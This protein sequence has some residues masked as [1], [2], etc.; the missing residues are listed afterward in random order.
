M[1]TYEA[2]GGVSESLKT[3]LENTIELPGSIPPAPSP[4]PVWIGIPPKDDELDGNPLLNLFLY[5]ITESPF[6]K[7]Q[8]IPRQT[9]QTSYG[10]PPLSLV[11]HY[12]VTP[13]GRLAGNGGAGASPDEVPAHYVLGSAM[14]VL[15]DNPVLTSGSTAAGNI[16]L[17]PSLD[18]AYEKVKLR[19]EPI[20]L[21]DVSKVWTALGRPYRLS[22]AYELSVI[23]IESRKPRRYPQLVGKPPPEGPRVRSVA[24]RNP[25]I[26][27]VQGRRLPGPYAAVDDELVVRGEDLAGDSPRVFFGDVEAPVT[28]ARNDRLTVLVPDDPRLALGPQRV[29]VVRQ[30]EFGSPPVL[31]VGARSNTGVWMFVPRVDTVDYFAGGGAPPWVRV[32]GKRLYDKNLRCIA[33][34]DDALIESAD[35]TKKDL[36][37]TEIG[38]AFPSPPAA[39]S[40]HRVRVL[41]NEVEALAVPLVEVP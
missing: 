11:L 9:P 41:V 33:F 38:V 23:Q 27:E 25:L 37:G 35:W 5:R 31:R 6:L 19:L 14:R 30:V 40:T 12:L 20:S 8:E 2:I 21:E 13:Y 36:T 10:H 1:S 32:R 26:M 22:A 15:H 39:K 24:E 7:N 4:F 18:T 16:V 3:L 34:I 28:S 17:E 29:N